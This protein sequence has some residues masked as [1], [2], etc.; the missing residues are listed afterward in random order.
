MST[1]TAPRGKLTA[2]EY[3]EFERAAD[4]RHEFFDGE[5]FAMSGASRK[6]ILI[7]SNLARLIGNAIV[8]RPCELYLTEMR[9][10][11][12]ENGLYTYPDLSIVGAKPVFQD[13]HFDTL[14][15]PEVL[16]EILSPSTE[17]YDRGRKFELYRA[18]PS[19]REYLML[20]QDRVFAEHFTRLPDGTWNL[21]ELHA[22]DRIVLPSA[23][24][25]FALKEAY[26]KVFDPAA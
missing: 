16:M 25:D 8:E 19:L 4:V 3:L 26:L 11:V 14:Q 22:G 20:A 12:E 18:L 17:G 23:G 15:N 6:H 1:A 9:V 7:V 24:C 5:L 10:R 21:R 2:A 13:G